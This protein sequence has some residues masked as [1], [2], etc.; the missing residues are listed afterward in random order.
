MTSPHSVLFFLLC[1]LATVNFNDQFQLE[2][3]KVHDV[4]SYGF[5]A[6]EPESLETAIA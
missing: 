5:L 1:M 2:T 4:R 6:P 3:N